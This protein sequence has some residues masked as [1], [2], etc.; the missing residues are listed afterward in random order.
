VQTSGGATRVAG[1]VSATGS[2]GA[3]GNIQL[4][5]SRVAVVENSSVN[6]SGATRGGQILVGGDYQGA[7]AAIQ[8][9]SNT[10]VGS[11]ATLRADATQSGDGGRIVVWC[12]W[13]ELRCERARR[14][15]RAERHLRA[16]EARLD[17]S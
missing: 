9:S 8:N 16:A 3:G 13:A 12:G 15:L 5:G 4:L 1:D 14:V 11:S 10:F 2:S 6:A 7:N 17:G